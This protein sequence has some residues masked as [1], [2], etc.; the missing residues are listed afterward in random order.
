MSNLVISLV[1]LWDG[2]TGAVIKPA[3]AAPV[4]TDPAL[5]IGISPNSLASDNTANGAKLPVM[6]AR[7][8]AAAPVWTEGN[9]VPLSVDLAGNA[10]TG[11]SSWFGSTAPTVG[12]K[13]AANSIPVVL[14]SDQPA[15]SV[16]KSTAGTSNVAAPVDASASSVTILASNASRLGAVIT[17]ASTATL[18]LKF[19]SS[20]SATS[21][22]FKLSPDAVLIVDSTLL[23]TGVIDGIWSA[24]NGKAYVTE[25]TA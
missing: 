2:T 19:G 22:T 5:V 25:L 21:W 16:Q 15:L 10:R 17:N 8:N 11:I 12:Q 6:G 20:A 14:A 3:S 7:A 23:Y 4:A 1:R 18:Y 9:Q 24:A 13:A